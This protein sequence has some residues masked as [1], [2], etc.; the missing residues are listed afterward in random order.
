MFSERNGDNQG[1]QD[2][3]PGER[4]ACDPGKRV[5]SSLAEQEDLYTE[6]FPPGPYNHQ[7]SLQVIWI[8]EPFRFRLPLAFITYRNEDACQSPEATRKKVAV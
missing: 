1:K 8:I 7:T 3:D 5:I 6:E 2:A 4:D